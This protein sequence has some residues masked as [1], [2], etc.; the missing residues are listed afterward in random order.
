MNAE[1]DVVFYEV[2]AE[3]EAAIRDCW[4]P[5]LTAQFY[6]DTIQEAGHDQPPARFISIRT[7]SRIPDHWINSL[8]AILSRSTGHDHIDHLAGKSL[9]LG[10]LPEY[11]ARS[12]AEHAM[13][14]WTALL[15]KLPRAMDQ[16]RQ[17]NRDGLTGNELVNKTMLVIGVGH[18]GIEIVRLAT[19]MGLVVHGHDLEQ[20][21]D[22]VIYVDEHSDFSGYDII[23]CAMNLTTEN[24]G[25][26]NRPFFDRV[27]RGCVFINI[28]RGELSPHDVLLDN[29]HSGRLGGV[30]L[31]VFDDESNLA[32]AL[33]AGEQN[34]DTQ[35]LMALLAM[36]N[37]I[38]TPHNA[39]NTQEATTRKCAQSVQQLEALLRDG[40]FI[41]PV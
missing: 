32:N 41:W 33:R 30:G 23:V 14:L 11:C 15:K 12:V 38:L 6:R 26:F 19:A 10:Y 13:L 29:L 28:A 3:E 36:P 2:F 39:F 34:D 5:T 37:V 21:Y 35:M 16:L 22:D 17:F 25:Y 18:I 7:Q 27:K 8:H 9:Q 1:C 20:R 24:Q 4:P 31:D 40:E